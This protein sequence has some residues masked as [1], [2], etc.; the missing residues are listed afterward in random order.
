MQLENITYLVVIIGI[1][2]LGFFAFTNDLAQVNTNVSIGIFETFSKIIFWSV[3][4][5]ISFYLI[6][7][8]IVH[9]SY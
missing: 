1:V 6:F 8:L 4:L 9:L 5:F 3:S 7:A 2:T